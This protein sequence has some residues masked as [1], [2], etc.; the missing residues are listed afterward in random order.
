MPEKTKKQIIFYLENINLGV[1]GV[2]L[3]FL[4]L[5]FLS[6]TTDPYTLPKQILLI[7][8]ASILTIIFGIKTI[9]DGKIKLRPS[10][11]DL[12]VFLIAV[13]ALVS[14]VLSIN[15]TDSLIAVVPFLFSILLYFIITNI[16]KQPS[17]LLLILASIVAGAVI[18]SILSILSFFSIFILPFPYTQ[19]TY[20]N[21]FGSL[22]DQ[23]IYFALVLPV[24][25]YFVY[26]IITTLKSKKKSAVFGTNTS[27]ASHKNTETAISPV[28]IGFTVAFIIILIGIIITAIQ[29]VTTQKPLILPLET[30]F[31]TALAAISQDTG[32]V[33]LGFLFG[34]GFGTYLTDF[35]RYKPPAFNLDPNLWQFTFFRSSTLILELLATTGILGLLAFLFLVYKIIKERNFFLPLILAL[36]SVFILPFTFIL[37]TL[38][39]ILLAIFAVIRAHNNP[40]KFNEIEFY[41]VALKRGLL[42]ARAEGEPI[43]QNTTE[44]R[45]S[46]FLPILFLII[47][48]ALVGFPVYFSFKLFVSDIIYRNSLTAF[49]QNNGNETFRLQDLS[50]KTFPYRDLYYR[51]L[52]QVD[53]ALANALAVKAKEQSS[54]TQIQQ[55]ILQLI[56]NA[57]T[58]GRNAA[59][60][61]PQSSYNW[62][63]LSSIYRSLIGFGEN[64]DKF[65]E[66]TNQQA[67]ALDPNNPQQYIELGG[68][69]YQTGKYDDAIR[70]F[71]LALNMKNDFAN[72]YYNLGHAL[73]MKG[74]LQEALT[75]YQEVQ[76]LVTNDPENLNKIN[77]EIQALQNKIATQQQ[78]VPSGTSQAQIPAAT[79]SAEPEANTPEN[80]SLNVNKPPA[81]LPERN[82][83]VKIPGLTTTPEPT[84]SPT[85]AEEKGPFH[86]KKPFTTPTPTRIP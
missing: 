19:A 46:K 81:K 47:T 11:F 18:S 2:F 67:I 6:A 50:I 86:L 65:A 31:R 36:I 40:E 8:A 73:E 5:F 44:R 22:L 58:N 12:Q 32:R 41:F 72:A 48:L 76:K 15:R 25:G 61:A 45:Y 26:S 68:I 49:S 39:F 24:T 70:Q 33:F 71:Q 55:T 60:I 29:L 78:E 83:K 56:Q 30:G 14:S 16:V 59:A 7:G 51:G 43:H 34:S 37:Q 38:F 9:I 54:N 80:E 77:A 69:Y 42:T 23:V 53:I 74:S 3:L 79:T 13:I 21:T 28:N 57:I 82:P 1:L 52:S 10:P 35:T 17:Q 64:A 4:P 27:G 20:F 84:V 75:M 66:L 85:P 62:N 63:N